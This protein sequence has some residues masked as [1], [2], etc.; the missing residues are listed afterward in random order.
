MMLMLTFFVVLVISGLLVWTLPL[1]Q[2]WFTK[3]EIFLLFLFTSY[4]CQ[5]MF[6]FISS[7]F[8]RITVVPEHFPFWTVRLQYGVIFAITLIWLMAVYRSQATLFKKLLAT[9]SWIVFGVTVEKI[10]LLIGVL[11]SDSKS[12]YPSLDMFFEMVVILIT[13]SFTRYLHDTLKRE[14]II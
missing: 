12:W 2:K 5:H 7:P 10:F 14:R 9:F 11:R 4:F 13:L 6:Y 8:D 3:I 1:L